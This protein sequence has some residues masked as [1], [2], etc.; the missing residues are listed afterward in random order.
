M[1]QSEGQNKT[2]IISVVHRNLAANT[3]YYNL[4]SYALIAFYEFVNGAINKYSKSFHHDRIVV[5]DI[6]EKVQKG[7]GSIQ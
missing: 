1:R 6:L 7:R 2:N 5:I 3:E 4:L